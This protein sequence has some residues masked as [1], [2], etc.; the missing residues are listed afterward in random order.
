MSNIFRID[1]Y[2][3]VKLLL[4]VM[5]RRP[6]LV[7]FLEAIVS[8][9]DR[10]YG[11]FTTNRNANLYRLSVTPQVCFLEKALNDRFDVSQRR[12][13]IEDGVFYD[14]QYLYTEGESL[15]EYVYMQSENKDIYLYTRSETGS[16][17]V[18]FIIV[19]PAG[20]RYNE[21]EMRALVDMYKL[22]S[23][24]FIISTI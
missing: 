13:Y 10:L 24:T 20:I 19:V 15:D 22:A 5:L 23:K 21:A 18:D 4:P 1:Y 7:A 16:G 17:S 6:L 11:L 9:I 12:I 2:R 3:L 14:E 8:P